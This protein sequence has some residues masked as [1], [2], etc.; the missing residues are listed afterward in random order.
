MFSSLCAALIATF[1]SRAALQ[2]E[3]LVEILALRHQIGVLHRS[4]KRPKF[5]PAD[6]FLWAGLCAVWNDWRSNIFLVKASTL[7]GWH[8]KGFRLFWTWR[9]RRGKRGRPA[10]PKEIRVLIRTMSRDNPLW[11]AP[12]I[13]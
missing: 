9:I 13:H 6:R 11:G 1:R 7:I 12:R 10:V 5:N 3:I 8:R 2:L 4:V